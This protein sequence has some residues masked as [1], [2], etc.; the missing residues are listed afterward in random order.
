[1]ELMG[2][3]R[4]DL[5]LALVFI[6][7]LIIAVEQVKYAKQLKKLGMK[8]IFIFPIDELGLAIAENNPKAF[9]KCMVMHFESV[10]QFVDGDDSKEAKRFLRIYL[11]AYNLALSGLNAGKD[12]LY[13]HKVLKD[14]NSRIL[15]IM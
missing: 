5:Y 10:A 13:A 2:L 6:G 4:A 15:K 7:F 8:M 11:S 9:R 14:G 3:N 1:M 12:I